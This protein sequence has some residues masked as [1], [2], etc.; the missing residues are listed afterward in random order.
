M[1]PSAR[2]L[3][4]PARLLLALL[5]GALL[6]ALALVASPASPASA[7]DELVSSSPAE[8]ETLAT[9]PTQ[10]QLTFSGEISNVGIAFSL[11]DGAGTLLDLPTVPSIEGSV[12]SIEL[13]ALT[14]GPYAL[15][16][17]VVS[18]DGHPIT[19]TISFAV[20]AAEAASADTAAPAATA[21]ETDGAT[22]VGGD[23]LTPSEPL[24][25][26]AVIAI[27]VGGFAVLVG[28]I[29]GIVARFRRH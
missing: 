29:I 17:R 4:R 16:W 20:G 21:G 12:V 23:A 10:A 5:A 9:A 13:P 15:T 2:S 22:A 3:T 7:H 19:G 11:T 8:G 25:G 28:A 6:A 27:A 18:S 26:W 24:P 14:D 1:H